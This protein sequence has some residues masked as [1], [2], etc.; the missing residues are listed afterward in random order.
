M[1]QIILPQNPPNSIHLNQRHRA[2]YC[3]RSSVTLLEIEIKILKKISQ[4]KKKSNL[5]DYI[6]M[7]LS[8]KKENKG[9]KNLGFGGGTDKGVGKS[10]DRI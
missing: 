7:K 6:C 9:K 2:K 3:I 8:T 1:K 5:R 4:E 10:T